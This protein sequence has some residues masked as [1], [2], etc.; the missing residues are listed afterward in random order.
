[1]NVCNFSFYRSG[2][3]AQLSSR[4]LTK[5]WWRYLLVLQLYQGSIGRWST[6]R[7]TYMMIGRSRSSL[8][9]VKSIGLPQGS[10][11][12]EGEN[13]PKREVTVFVYL[14]PNVKSHHFCHKLFHRSDSVGPT[15]TQGRKLHKG[16]GD[17]CCL[18]GTCHICL[19]VIAKP[20]ALERNSLR[21]EISPLRSF[22]YLHSF[23]V[24]FGY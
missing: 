23:F 8:S 19:W 12:S 11:Q 4:T 21:V 10:S 2:V 3:R 14:T 9:V 1:M 17:H 20:C 24:H 5:V 22:N 18:R 7:L 13:T 15:H 16:G 6:S